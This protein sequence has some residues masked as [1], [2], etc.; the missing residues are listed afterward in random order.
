MNP[1][2]QAALDRARRPAP[3]PTFST[4]AAPKPDKPLP[5]PVATG[6]INHFMRLQAREDATDLVRSLRATL[7]STNGLAQVI[8]ALKRAATGR[9]GSTVQGYLDIIELLEKGNEH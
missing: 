7:D 4:M 2:A 9:P 8:N 5:M 6:P 1:T 3:A